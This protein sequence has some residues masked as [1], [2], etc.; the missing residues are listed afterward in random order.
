[1]PEETFPGT[2]QNGDLTLNPDFTFIRNNYCVR[3]ANE[4]DP[5]HTQA[6]KLVT[7]MYGSR[8]LRTTR[9]SLSGLRPEHRAREQVTLTAS[10][11][12]HVVGTLTL[13][14]DAGISL[15]ADTLYRPEV[16]ALR[17]RG[18][19]LCEVTRL[20]LHPKL[21]SPDVMA[22]LFHVAFVLASK[23]HGRTDLIAEVH[24]RHARFYRRTMGY[25]IAGPERICPRVG[26]P[27]V[28][29]HL[30]LDFASSQIR[31]LAGTCTQRDRNLYRRFLPAAEQEAL[32]KK[33][34]VADSV[35]A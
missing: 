7:S 16:D 11:D 35:S 5:L 17:T 15:L 9:P 18:S 26:A 28:L 33:L 30:P 24:P 4:G 1:M 10:R 21:S 14:V 27:A 3:L 13:G 19:R 25:Q 2:D 31:Q 23:V 20:A 22:T 32:L 8:G 6:S 34:V 12:H 29:L